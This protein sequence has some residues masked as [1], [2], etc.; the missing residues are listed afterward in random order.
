[1]GATV[2]LAGCSSGACSTIPQSTRT[3]VQGDHADQLGVDQVGP[4]ER[5][6]G[7]ERLQNRQA[8]RL[9]ARR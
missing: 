8:L 5:L 6:F 2:E 4:G 1:M 9:S 7:L 3:I